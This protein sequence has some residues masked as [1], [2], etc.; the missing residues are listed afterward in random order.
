MTTRRA[1]VF[2]AALLPLV[3][4]AAG[5]AAPKAVEGIVTKVTSGDT[6]WLTPTGATPVEVKLAG[7]EAPAVCQPWGPEARGAL[8]EMVL[9]QH[10]ELRPSG[11]RDPAGRVVGSVLVDGVDVGRRL[12][13][14]G[15]AWSARVKWD[16]GPFVKQERMAHALGRGLHGTPGAL[17][18][19]EWRRANGACP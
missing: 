8:Q 14:E 9:Q 19:S 7:I 11:A 16:H 10:V 6:L 3:A 5:H 4:A 17:R 18:P 13:E 1:A 12:V 15:H 2:A